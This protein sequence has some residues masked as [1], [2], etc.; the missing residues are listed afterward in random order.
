[1]LLCY[2]GIFTLPL[3]AAVISL[4]VGRY[5]LSPSEI[6]SALI[7][8]QTT[9]ASR[10]VIWEIRFPR[11]ILALAVGASLSVSGTAFQ[12]LFRNPLVS[13]GILG[14]SAGAGFGA[15][16]AIIVFHSDTMIYLLAF[17]FG[18]LAV[19]LSYWAGRIC[20]PDST[21]TLVL[22]GVI[23][24]SVFSS[25]LSLAKYMADPNNQLPTIVYWLMGSLASAGWDKIIFS[26][27]LMGIGIIGLLSLRWRL[28]VVSMGDREAQSMGIDLRVTK[29]L[30]VIF[31]TL[32][33]AG[34][35]CAA[36][37]VGWVGLVMPHIGRML[38]G[39]DN[40]RLVPVSIA[41][42]AAF[43]VLVDDL[44]RCISSAEIPLG[45]LTALIGGP[46]FIWLLKKTKGGGWN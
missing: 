29:I 31:A 14:V 35:V 20:A 43:L 25:L 16:L 38:V 3:I 44:A 7:G 9:D 21:V 42:G 39:N 22:G 18:T 32:A 8:S 5:G 11:I 41:L 10:A 13:P 26:F 12:G 37:I 2:I 30:T 36:G 46:Y 1:M 6:F 27:P 15:A 23:I 45:V 34:A 33:T 4:F 19:L 28:N 17:L 40:R 24:S